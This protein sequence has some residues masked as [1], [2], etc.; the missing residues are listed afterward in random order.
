MKT[1][2]RM[3]V[4]GLAAL[5]IVSCTA[6]GDAGAREETRPPPRAPN[7]GD[8]ALPFVEIEA[9]A[10]A[11]PHGELR[12]LLTSARDYQAFVGSPPPENLD[13]RREWVVLY[14]AGTM[15]TGGYVAD[16]SYIGRSL[17]GRTLT[18]ETKLI[19]PGSNCFVTQA[20]TNP[21]VLVRFPRPNEARR[22]VFTHISEV[23]DCGPDP[24]M[25]SEDVDTPSE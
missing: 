24:M 20:L 16:I 2:S 11:R 14:A 3:N 4:L 7:P 25:P 10:S 6:L 1:F 22:V 9:R 21:Y 18:I 17:D 8:L 12:H 19:E 23:R 15:S 13:F 5:A